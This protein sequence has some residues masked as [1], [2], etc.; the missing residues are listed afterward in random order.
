MAKKSHLQPHEMSVVD[1]EGK[2]GD[3]NK[4]REEMWVT[5][6]AKKAGISII[7]G[8]RC[9]HGLNIIQSDEL[10]NDYPNMGLAEYKKLKGIKD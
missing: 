4:F 6:E 8:R 10:N 2:V 5:E 9:L 7:N 3:Y 1:K